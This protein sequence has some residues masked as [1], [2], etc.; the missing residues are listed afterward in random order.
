M[1]RV[2]FFFVRIIAALVAVIAFFTPLYQQ[3]IAQLEQDK[4]WQKA[5]VEELA[6]QFAAG[7]MPQVNERDFFDGDLDLTLADGLKF[8]ELR[9]VATHNSYQNESV[10]ELQMWYGIVSRVTFGAVPANGGEF[11]LGSLSAQLDG[12]VRSLEM[13]VEIMRNGG[14]PSFVCLHSPVLDMTTNS[15]DFALALREI[16]LWSKAHP[17]HLPITIIIEPK[18]A[19]LP[20]QN[21]DV[22][23]LENANALDAL[24]KKALGSRLVTPKDVLRGYESFAQMRE[25]DDWPTVQSLRGKVLVLLH[26]TLVTNSYIRQDKSLRTQ[27][28]F[29]MLRVREANKPYAAFLI[30]N[31]PKKMEAQSQTLIETGNYIVRTRADSFGKPDAQT[32][33]AALR[34]GAQILSTDYPPLQGI[35]TPFAFSNSATLAP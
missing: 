15:Y 18:V 13:D 33:A 14:K 8:N 5:H 31:D 30:E 26:S 20:L 9:Y 27:A 4:A 10:P 23:T 12:G 25:N 28:M 17:Q 35:E 29:P 16:R 11:Q 22:F 2:L 6:Q 32:R 24:L 7:T 34:S 1:N 19:M 3:N 21:M